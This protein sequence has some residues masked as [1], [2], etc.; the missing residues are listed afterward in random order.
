MRAGWLL[1]ALWLVTAAGAV[2]EP[3]FP[4]VLPWDDAAPGVTDL[5]GWLPR[6][7]GAAGF[8][9]VG[10]DGHLQVGGR[11]LRL[12][13]IDL[14]YSAALPT[15]EQAEKVAARLAK[16][17]NNIVRFHIIDQQRSPNG[18]LAADVKDTRTFDPAMLDRLDYFTDQLRRRGIYSYLCLLNYRPF[19]AADGLPAEIEQL[20]N[21]YQGRHLIGFWDDAQQRLQEEY[22]RLLLS[23]RNAYSGLTYAADPAV[24]MV[25]I[26]NENGLLHGWLAGTVDSLPA[27]FQQQL[28]G[29]WNTWLRQRYGSTAKLAAA[30]D[31]GARPVGAELLR[32]PGPRGALANWELEQHEPAKATVALTTDGPPEPAGGAAVRIDLTAAG[33][34]SWHVRLVQHGLAVR[35]Q[36]PYTISGWAR[37]D[38]EGVLTGSLAMAHEPWRSLG[39]DQRL[40]L[41]TTWQ[42][43]RWLVYPPV[44]DDRVRLCLDPP[45]R[46]G[47]V[48]LAGLSLRPG[49]TA[50]LLDG[51]RLEGGRLGNLVVATQSQRARQVR[52]DWTRFLWETE[53][54]YWQR[55]Q[56]YL[57]QDLGVRCPVI[58]TVVGC[59]TPNLMA[60]LDVID[61]H[62]YWQHPAFPGRPWDRSNWYVNNISAVNAVGGLLPDLARHRVE[63]KPFAITEYGFP[64]TNTYGSEGSLLRAP[65]A[66]LQDWDYLSTSRY[67]QSNNFDC[68]MIR[69]WFDIDQHPPKMVTL[70]PAAAIFLRGD[71]AVAQQTVCAPL[72]LAQELELLPEQQRWNLIDLGPA[73]IAPATAL[74]HRISLVPEGGQAPAGAL[75]PDQVAVA[76]LRIV[77]DTGELCWDRTQPQR[78]VVT[79]D[80][81]RSKMVVGYGA[82]QRYELSGL[83]VAPGPTRQDG[84]SALT[85]TAMQGDLRGGVAS[86]LLTATG[87]VENSG[88]QW[89][90]PDRR[91]VNGNWGTAPTLVEGIPAQFTLASPA[92][93]TAVW[94][95]DERGQRREPVPVTAAAEGRATFEIGPRY[96]TLWYEVAVR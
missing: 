19:N 31:G 67:A 43:F 95:L 18:L 2:P 41:S 28:Q 74:R 89:T 52:L 16:F 24:A 77:S 64:A 32:N 78:G 1:L 63:G 46:V 92:A 68:A 75:R 81:P 86:V 50:G 48:W 14:T 51:E 37:A 3:L 36:Q 29:Q 25:E 13:G 53:D 26:N 35:G 87:D 23:H 91:S 79:C 20:P 90:G 11:R 66:C 65:Y 93:R 88:W 33:T 42:P 71:V 58:G 62:G 10:R 83:T 76:G 4:F 17:G 94:A 47:S 27:V 84:W 22:A 61:T 72:P 80:T 34:Q 9:V 54:R 57:K 44:D 30:W 40:K 5:S 6:P 21:P 85:V 70:L 49:G 8:V 69:G 55:L 60:R 56:R 39:S 45:Q 82:G 38:G 59:S 12:H 15:H 7:A 73:A 96:R